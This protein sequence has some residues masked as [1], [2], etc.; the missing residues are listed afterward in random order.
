M[1]YFKRPLRRLVLAQA[2]GRCLACGT[3]DDLTLDHVRPRALGGPTGVAWAYQCLCVTCN[4]EKGT[5]CTGDLLVP[6]G[7]R[8]LAWEDDDRVYF[9]H[10][11]LLALAA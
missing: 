10:D 4:Q 11:V 9:G 1:P 7:L 3:S 2:D 5:D 8:A 6:A